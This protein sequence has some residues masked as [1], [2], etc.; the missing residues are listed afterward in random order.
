ML[1]HYLKKYYQIDVFLILATPIQ[2][3]LLC[4]CIEVS[5][6]GILVDFLEFVPAHE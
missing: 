2:R 3:E 1:N 5:T 4:L 6:T